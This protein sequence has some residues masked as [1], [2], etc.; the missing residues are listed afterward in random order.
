MHVT[1][2]M[3]TYQ[4][5]LISCHQSSTTLK[6]LIVPHRNHHQP[7][8]DTVVYITVLTTIW[9]SI[10][11]SGCLTIRDSNT[12][13]Y[14]RCNPYAQRWMSICELQWEGPWAIG[15]HNPESLKS[16]Q[17]V[18]LMRHPFAK[19]REVRKWYGGKG[20]LKRIPEVT[21]LLQVSS[22]RH[23]FAKERE[24]RKWF[25]WGG[26]RWQ[27]LQL[28]GNKLKSWMSRLID[29]QNLGVPQQEPWWHL[30]PS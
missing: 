22:M 19:E 23:S 14:T 21:A 30:P 20:W 3:E 15:K 4:W 25:E 18:S 13:Y 29:C 6:V 12:T 9:L 7:K 27:G 5:L 17:L 26:N 28:R 10:Y 16:L 2:Q 1:L 11:W 24:V 8:Y